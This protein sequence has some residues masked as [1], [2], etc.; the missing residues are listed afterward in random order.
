ML[1]IPAIDIKDGQTVRLKQGNFSE[2]TVYSETPVESALSFQGFGAKRLH[3]VDLDGAESGEP[4]NQTIIEKI[5]GSVKVPIQLGGG[6]RSLEAIARW[7]DLGIQRVIIGTLAVENPEI[8]KLALRKFGPERIIVSVDALGGMVAIE[9]W[10][11]QSKIKAVDLALKYKRAGLEKILYTDIGRDG[12]LTGPNLNS[13][14]E[15]AVQTDLKI[16]ASGGVSSKE[17]LNDLEN[18][19]Q[20]GVDSVIIGRAFYEGRLLPGEVL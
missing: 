13:I 7:L 8:V 14:K 15:I 5:L 19:E 17:D 6:I 12:M 20:Y 16:I 1:V 11:K 9:G 2:K 3:L 4:P 10:Q 18:L